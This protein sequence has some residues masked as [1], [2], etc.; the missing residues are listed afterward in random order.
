MEYAVYRKWK[1][2]LFGHQII[3]NYVNITIGSNFNI[4]PFCQLLAQGEPG[5]AKIVIGN[6]VA[7]NFNVMINA[8]LGGEIIIGNNVLIGPYTIMRATN[9]NFDNP[10]IPI[11]EQGHKPGKIILEDD[12]WIGSNVIILPNVKIG[13]SAI[14]GAGSVVTKSIPAMAIA[15]GVP[16]KV[17]SMRK[18]SIDG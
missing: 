2:V 4:G 1:I 7:L 6:R 5:K 10:K 14:I 3:T 12:V 15:A 17:I 16:A 18:L 8:D 11:H 9:H 13:Q